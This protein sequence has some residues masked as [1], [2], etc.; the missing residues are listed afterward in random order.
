MSKILIT[1]GAGF[2]GTALIDQLWKEHEITIYDNL[3]PQVHG[4][5]TKIKPIFPRAEFIYGDVRDSDNFY[6]SM[7][8]KDIIIHLAAET[9]TSQ[10]MTQIQHYLDVNVS[11]MATLCDYI[12]NS[13]NKPSKVLLA[14]SRAVYGEGVYECSKCGVIY[15]AKRK[16]DTSFNV[17]CPICSNSDIQIL[18]IKETADTETV[19]IY[20]MTKLMQEQVLNNTSSN[21][22]ILRLQNVYGIGQSLINTHTGIVNHF[23]KLALKNELISIYEDGEIYRD[24][25]FIDDVVSAFE[26]CIKSDDL[27]ENL[28]LNI[29]SGV[30]TSLMKVAKFIVDYYNS[31]SSI[32]ISGQYR[33]GDIKGSCSDNSL[34][35]NKINYRPQFTLEEDLPI[36]LDWIR[37]NA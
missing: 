18:P 36:L 32:V 27:T 6:R 30:S 13:T 10:S 28:T 34:A 19:S 14:S 3:N 26:S 23:A 37:N 25:V 11:S 7:V 22:Y 29:G 9:G 5:L 20:G 31:S 21:S 1:G 16:L 4:E 24:F 2:I 35:R 12:V 15:P 33:E 8:D 17:F